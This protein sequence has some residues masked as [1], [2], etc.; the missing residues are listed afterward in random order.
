MGKLSMLK[1]WYTISKSEYKALTNPDS[2][3]Y[4]KYL[5][6][7]KKMPFISKLVYLSKKYPSL[8][9]IIKKYINNNLKEINITTEKN[10]TP[11]Y[12]AIINDCSYDLIMYLLNNGGTTFSKKSLIELVSKYSKLSPNTLIDY[13]IPFNDKNSFPLH[14]AIINNNTNT[15]IKLLEHY[16]VNVIDN[17][18][19]APIHYAST[20][21][22]QSSLNLLLEHGANINLPTSIGDTS[23]ILSIKKWFL[24][25]AKFLINAGADVNIKNNTG[26]T[27]LHLACERW[28]INIVTLLLSNGANI[29]SLTKDNYSPLMQCY[30]CNN[31]NIIS[32]I[33]ILLQNKAKTIIFNKIYLHVLLS[34]NITKNITK[35][36]E[37]KI[38][39]ILQMYLNNPNNLHILHVKDQFGQNLLFHAKMNVD[40]IKYLV[41][42]GANI[43]AINKKGNTIIHEIM[44][45]PEINKSIVYDFLEKIFILGIDVH[46]KNNDGISIACFLNLEPPYFEK[47]NTPLLKIESAEITNTPLSTP[48]ECII[49]YTDVPSYAI[50]PC[51]HLILC[52]KCNN[53][54]AKKLKECPICKDKI[55][56]ICKIFF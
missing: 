34:F 53:D 45:N 10:H 41:S 18:G 44:L 23:L 42:K 27:A 25:N 3:Y 5:K 38:L 28:D 15:I 4:Y 29:N 7:C 51:G 43:N 33:N 6:S 22:S 46:I 52:D 21:F 32:I 12:I 49:C 26:H 31:R 9:V 37:N 13:L 8:I 36:K 17:Y 14:I 50:I 56:Q 30:N 20:Y 16:D 19:F 11:L 35:E 40:I 24:Y 55:T 48:R 47:K 1:I 39:Q 54:H 2:N